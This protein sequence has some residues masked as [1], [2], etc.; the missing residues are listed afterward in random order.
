MK[1]STRSMMV[2]TATV[3]V[4]SNT[5]SVAPSPLVLESSD[6][7]AV[8]QMGTAGYS[9]TSASVPDFSCTVASGG[10]TATCLK[11]ARAAKGPLRVTLVVKSSGGAPVPT[12][13]I[14]VQ[15]N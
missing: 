7:T 15:N 13:D 3:T 4:A 10:Q 1:T 2:A 9:I 11:S 8:F 6:T 5:A 12:G 14:W